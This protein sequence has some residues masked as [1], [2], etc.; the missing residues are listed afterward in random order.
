MPQVT[1]D[2]LSYMP[3]GWAS[4]EIRDQHALFCTVWPQYLTLEEFSDIIK[5]FDGPGW[6]R[7]KQLLWSGVEYAEVERTAGEHDMQTLRTAMGPLMDPDHP[8]C[9]KSN[10]NGKAWSKYIR[11]AS[12]IF[13][14]RIS[15]GDVATI[16]TP[17][18][19]DCFHPSEMTNLQDIE[20]PVLRGDLGNRPVPRIFLWHPT[21][22]GAPPFRYQVW[23]DDHTPSRYEMFES[24]PR[25]TKTWR[26]VSKHRVPTKWAVNTTVCRLVTLQT[27]RKLKQLS[28]RVSRVAINVLDKLALLLKLC[29][30]TAVL[31]VIILR[32]VFRVLV[33]EE[34]SPDEAGEVTN[35]SSRVRPNEEPRIANRPPSPLT[36]AIVSAVTSPGSSPANR[37]ASS[38][39]DQNNR[40]PA[41]EV[42]NGNQS[43]SVLAA[44]RASAVSEPGS[45][46]APAEGSSPS[47]TLSKKEAKALRKL[48]R[49]NAQAQVQASKAKVKKT[50]KKSP[51]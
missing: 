15:R 25:N 38:A 30:H 12:L 5:Q 22:Q 35:A 19:P 7:D 50:K 47:P 39:V 29:Y 3:N 51:Q 23:P 33:A 32:L 8:R 48:Q 36:T 34:A 2:I 42:P 28:S 46:S 44:G 4:A 24:R 27:F 26:V 6:V 13:A 45:S 40:S 31:L 49:A 20:L 43:P 17:P 18:P 10:K 11:G 41:L 14:R 21:V 1:M 9:L 16:M 37:V